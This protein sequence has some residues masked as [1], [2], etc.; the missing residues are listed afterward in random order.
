M[1]EANKNKKSGTVIAAALCAINPIYHIVVT[2]EVIDA[3]WNG[4]KNGVTENKTIPFP[5][6]VKVQS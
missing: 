3:V 6:N 1:K 4:I 2:R 5:K